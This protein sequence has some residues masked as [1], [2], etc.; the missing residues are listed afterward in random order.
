MAT[1][2]ILTSYEDDENGRWLGFYEDDEL[3][4]IIKFVG[5]TEEE[6]VQNVQRFAQYLQNYVDQP[7]LLI[8][9][10]GNILEDPEFP[11]DDVGE[12]FNDWFTLA[13]EMLLD[14]AEGAEPITVWV[15]EEGE[16]MLSVI[17]EVGADLLAAL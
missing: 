17:E 16:T 2:Q 8:D 10:F 14:G 9:N 7:D 1:I 15:S 11:I 3:N 5:D 12:F 13:D 4:E 6:M